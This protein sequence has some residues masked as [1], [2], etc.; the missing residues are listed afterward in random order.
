V[1]N[2]LAE[3]SNWIVRTVRDHTH[4]KGSHDRSAFRC[5]RRKFVVLR[6]VPIPNLTSAAHTTEGASRPQ[7]KHKRGCRARGRTEVADP[8]RTTDGR[9]PAA[10]QGY[11]N[12][13]R[14]KSSKMF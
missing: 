7:S 6:S 2:L 5:L 11:G 1:R 3:C 8:S 9:I 10:K 13:F 14:I 4:G 12:K